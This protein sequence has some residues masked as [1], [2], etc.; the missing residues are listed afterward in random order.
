[1]LKDSSQVNIKDD[2]EE[3]NIIKDKTNNIK[4]QKY[5]KCKQYKH[6]VKTYQS[7]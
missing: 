1:M 6:Y 2:N 7:I 4:G 5:K 3:L